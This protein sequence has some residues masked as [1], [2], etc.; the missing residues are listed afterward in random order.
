MVVTAAMIVRRVSIEIILYGFVEG[1]EKPVLSD[2]VQQT[3]A[4]EHLV[5][6]ILKLREKELY[7]GFFGLCDQAQQRICGRKINTKI[8]MK[9]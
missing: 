7:F 4:P 5:H 1:Q 8:S 9:I 3:T 2:P 6:R